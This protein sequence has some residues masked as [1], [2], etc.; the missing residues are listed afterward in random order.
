MYIGCVILESLSDLTV[1]DGW[2]TIAKKVVDMP[3]DPDA[4]VWHVC[5][6]RLSEAQLKGRLDRLAAAMRPHWYAHFWQEDDLCV[7]LAGRAF[8]LS[9]GDRTAWEPMLAYAD[10][11][12]LERR[13]SETI[14]TT[15]PDYVREA[16]G[17]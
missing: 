14:P 6:Y 9:A 11:T 7:I 17:A 16:V 15:L 13:Y 3:N 10:A 1:L 5:W 8:W 12:G 4:Q 2:T